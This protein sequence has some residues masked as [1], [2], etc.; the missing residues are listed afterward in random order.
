MSAEHDQP[1][2]FGSASLR[3]PDELRAPLRRHLDDLRAHYRGLD[4][5]QGVLQEWRKGP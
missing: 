3:L 2:A 1:P 4:W 5:A